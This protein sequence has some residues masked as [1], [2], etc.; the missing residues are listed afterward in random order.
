MTD[1]VYLRGEKY[2][3]VWTGLK[4]TELEITI[5]K[6]WNNKEKLKKVVDKY[7]IC[8]VRYWKKFHD[9][10]GIGNKVKHIYPT[11]VNVKDDLRM[12]HYGLYCGDNK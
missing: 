12:K 3:P 9:M 7:G 4:P 6:C 10:V 8:V 5:G 1:Y 2:I 11:L